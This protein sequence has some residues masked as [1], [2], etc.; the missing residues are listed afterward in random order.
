[1]A[2]KFSIQETDIAISKAA[3]KESKDL[4]IG[5][6]EDLYLVLQEIM[7]EK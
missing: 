4:L 6:R 5:I 3:I 2:L 1:M 7:E